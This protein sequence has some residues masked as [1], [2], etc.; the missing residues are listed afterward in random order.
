MTRARSEQD[1]VCSTIEDG[2]AWVKLNRPEKRNC[3]T[4]S[5]TV[6]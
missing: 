5:S 4:P 3:M 1:T 2:I 6:G